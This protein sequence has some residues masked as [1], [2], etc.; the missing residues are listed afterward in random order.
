[1]NQGEGE[2][3]RL[4]VEAASAQAWGGAIRRPQVLLWASGLPA[5]FYLVMVLMPPL[6]HDAA[7]VLDFAQRWLDGRR[8]Y[9]DLIDVNPPLIFILSL[10]P[11]AIARNT[12]L[13]GP[14]ALLL[15]LLAHAFMLWR[16][17]V[18]LRRDRAEGPVESAVLAA[19][20]PLLLLVA[21]SDFG[22]R[23][24][25]MASSAIPYALLA[26][27][28]VD[29]PEVP[30]GLALGVAAVA[31]VAFAL[32][33][34]FL[35]VPLLVEMLVLKRVGRA[36]A[37]RD[38]VPALM[39]AVW[40]AYLVSIPAFFPA[41]LEEIVPLIWEIYGDIHGA[42]PLSVLVTD[43]MGAAVLLLLLALPL[44]LRRRAGTLAQALALAAAGAFLSAWV[45]H[46]GWTYHVLP[47]TILALATLAAAASRWADATL[48]EARAQAAAPALAV[49]AAFGIAA[50]AVR[51]GE[52]PWRQLWFHSE[53]AGR[54]TEWLRREVTRGNILVLSPEI[55]PVYPSVNYANLRPTLRTMSIW[56]LQG[57]YRTCASGASPYRQPAEM[58]VAEASFYRTVAEDFA[59]RPPRAVL[60]TR[61]AHMRGCPGRFD[62][63]EYF[64]RHPLFARTWQLYRLAGEM[65]GYRLFVRGR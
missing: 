9:V 15:C 25:L 10:L 30:R 50:Y 65:D 6:N 42:G 45:Q 52:T 7:A 18:A 1:M 36:R 62:L 38:P 58:G 31:A 23:E 19:A 53:Q 16:M 13:S 48:P 63:L 46:K 55:L 28:R 47:V 41:Y 39:A 27:R 35:A 57:A 64:S 24:V 3:G 43:L 32:K 26:A 14:Q 17:S 56:P 60:V 34:H 11:A 8:L 12:P 5:A 20:I 22:Q 21:G 40:L 49:I 37:L 2:A 44:A 54:L 59:R 61:F 33:P 4:P 51:G 29:G